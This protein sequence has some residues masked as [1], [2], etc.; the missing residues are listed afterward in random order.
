MLPTPYA[1]IVSYQL[2]QP[3]DKYERLF[4]ELKASVLWW[5]YLPTTWV[6]KRLE[7]LVELRAKLTPLIVESDRLL[8]MPARGPADGWLPT[9]AWTWLNTNIPREW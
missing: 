1:Y 5:H 4:T 9:E 6:V 3:T 8:I 2:T 7:T